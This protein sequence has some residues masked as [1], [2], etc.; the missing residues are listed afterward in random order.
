MDTNE[1]FSAVVGRRCERLGELLAASTPAAVAELSEAAR[2]VRGARPTWLAAQPRTLLELA[3]GAGAEDV[4]R[5]LL[6]FGVC[7]TP[8]LRTRLRGRDANAVMT[9]SR[10]ASPR[11][12]AMLLAEGATADA[13]NDEG[14]ALHVAI[15]KA[16][17]FRDK[18]AA[19]YD[20]AVECAALLL[21]AGADPGR[22]SVSGISPLHSAVAC[23]DPKLVAV[24]LSLGPPH[25]L[26]AAV[27]APMPETF[28]VADA[29]PITA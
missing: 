2:R 9:A 7:V 13:S 1:V 21:R 10:A 22:R 19:R 16:V 3:A 17:G 14:S 25:L 28:E 20:E 23:A 15:S 8:E 12:L 6:E 5:L 11:C 4:L 29:W 18:R 27:T 24:L 26:R